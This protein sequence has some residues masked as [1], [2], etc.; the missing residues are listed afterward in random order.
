MYHCEIRH[1]IEILSNIN[2]CEIRRKIEIP[3]E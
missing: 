1:K 3:I 2:R